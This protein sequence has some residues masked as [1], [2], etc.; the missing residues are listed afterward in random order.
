M[1]IDNLQV[2]DR[3]GSSMHPALV[4]LNNALAPDKKQREGIVAG[5]QYE[6]P[7]SLLLS[8]PEPGGINLLEVWKSLSLALRCLRKSKENFL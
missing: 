1:S 7:A 4:I 6:R 5:D 2:N 3:Y 8:G